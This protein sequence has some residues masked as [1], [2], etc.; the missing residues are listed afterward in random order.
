MLRA[1]VTRVLHT[2]LATRPH[3]FSLTTRFGL[4][5][6][7]LVCL[8]TSARADVGLLLGEPYGRGSGYNPTGHISVYLSRVC[9][10]TPSML[11][12]CRTDEAGSVIS[13]YNHI[14]PVD[15]VAIPLIPYLYAV[16]DASEAPTFADPEQVR[17]LRDRYRARHLADFEPVRRVTKVHDWVQLVGSAYDRQNV[18]FTIRTTVE[19]DDALIDA[20]NASDNRARFNLLFENCADFARDLI[21]R[22]YLPQALHANRIGDLGF[23]TPKHVSKMFVRYAQRHPELALQTFIVPQIPGNRPHSDRARGVLESL[24]RMKRYAIPLAVVQPWVSVGLAAGYLTTGRF[25]PQRHA[26]LVLSPIEVQGRAHAAVRNP[27]AP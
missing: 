3:P 27:P 4:P 8:A 2:H 1:S 9:A 16:D 12:R 25:N 10:E 24:V 6:L 18:V 14:P 26:P 19:Q 17:A 11:R 13:R 20:F 22:Y 23:T 21:N 5:L 15:W 7:V